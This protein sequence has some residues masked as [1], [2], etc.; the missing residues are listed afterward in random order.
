MV[1]PKGIFQIMVMPAKNR[2]L[3]RTKLETST[4]ES[5]SIAVFGAS[6]VSR[7]ELSSMN[8]LAAAFLNRCI[9]RLD[10]CKSNLFVSVLSDLL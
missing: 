6:V 8:M 1:G 5:S 2:A 7:R 3:F 10:K 9:L 4:L